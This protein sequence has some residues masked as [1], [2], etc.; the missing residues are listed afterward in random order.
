MSTNRYLGVDPMLTNV[1]IAYSNNNYIAEQVL[2]S[3][4]VAKQ[5]GKHFIYDR[6]RFRNLPNKRAAGSPSNEVT[7]TLTTGLPYFAEDHAL[8]QFVPDEDVENSITPTDPYVDA[9]EN[10][11]E[12][13]LIARELEVAG[14]L[15]D[16]AQM[17][18][19]IT[20]SGSSQFNDYGNSDPFSTIDTALQT[21]HSAIHLTPNTLIMGR[22]VWDK[23]KYHPAFLERIK[24]TQKGVL[25]P[26][27]LASLIGVERIIVGGA[28]YNTSKEGQTDSMSYIWGKHAILAYIAPRI[29]PKLMTLGLT[30]KWQEMQT[31]RLRGTDE[32][33]RKGTYIRVGGYYY[34]QNIVAA[35]A[36][37]LI[38]NAVA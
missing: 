14:M 1:A 27:L 21:V 17:T 8:K 31:E 37:Y 34:D 28:G 11:T 38:K 6:G 7:L 24:Y 10:V 16:T 19:N 23:L 3:F 4:P 13:H 30:Y 12:R 5:S 20:L 33:D 25:S 15:T 26:D 32:E 18:Q 35:P 29:A 36:G 22:Q 9:T 2:P